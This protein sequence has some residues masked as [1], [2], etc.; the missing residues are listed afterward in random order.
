MNEKLRATCVY[1]KHTTKKQ[2]SKAKQNE[3]KNYGEWTNTEKNDR[4]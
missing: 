2:Q 3:N 1:D 4:I